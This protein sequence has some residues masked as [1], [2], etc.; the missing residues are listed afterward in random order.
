MEALAHELY[1]YLLKAGLTVSLAKYINMLVLLV[2]AV[3]ILIV[4]QLTV[5]RFIISTANRIA[6]RTKVRFDDILVKNKFPRNIAQIVPLLVAAEL[7]PI[8]FIDFQYMENLAS[9]GLQIFAIVLVLW[10]ARSF[11][12]TLKDYFKTLPNLKDKPIDSYIQVF[13]IFAWAIGIISIF[14]VITEISFLKFF[15]TI[16]AA[17][18]IIILIF[19]DTILGF[20]ASIQVS[21][22][23]MV[24]IGDW[25]TFEKYGADGDVIEISLATVKVQNFDK[26]ITTIPTYALISESFKNWRGMTN[27]PGRRIKR[28][29]LIKQNSVQ[30]LNATTIEDLKKI[31][32]IQSYLTKRQEDIDKYNQVNN[33]DKS[34]DINGRNLT[35]LGVFRKYIET[36][37]QHHSAINKEMMIMSRQLPPTAEGIPLEVYAFSSDKRWENYEYIMAD[38]FDHLIAAIKYFDLELFELPNNSSFVFNKAIEH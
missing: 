21:I 20:V 11:L 37:L 5:R 13:M 33:I 14:A 9:K 36:Y 12:N 35:N 27:S 17:S 24:R 38:I 25:I 4:I 2:A 30:F 31:Q 15:T 16:G 22:N 7:L 8:I 10:I 29:L 26:T 1:N 19:R 6:N 23:D 32:L 28:A 18:A 3:I 34:I